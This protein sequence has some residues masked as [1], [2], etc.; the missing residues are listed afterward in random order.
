MKTIDQLKERREILVRGIDAIREQASC[1]KADFR[2]IKRYVKE[3]KLIDL[4]VRYIETGPTKELARAQIEK[5]SREVDVLCSRYAQWDAPSDRDFKSDSARRVFYDKSV[6]ITH[7]KQ[8]LQTLK[9]L[10]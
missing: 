8:Q 10:L 5:L 7:R 9:Y 2:T 6:G 4:C 1:T 3:I